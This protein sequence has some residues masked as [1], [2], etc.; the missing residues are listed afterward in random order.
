[1]RA[2]MHPHDRDLDR[3]RAHTTKMSM[4]K[5]IGTA[6]FGFIA[7]RAWSVPGCLKIAYIFEKKGVV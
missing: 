1:M 5:K 2:L 7:T 3:S 6:E 4:Q